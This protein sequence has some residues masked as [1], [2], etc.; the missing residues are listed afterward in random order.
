[1]LGGLALRD[2]RCLRGDHRGVELLL[3]R[4]ADRVRGEKRERSDHDDK[5]D[6]AT[7]D[8]FHRAS[9]SISRCAA[10]ARAT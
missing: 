9:R 10:I 4:D 2:D 5:S 6:P 7:G 1:M 8:A 3:E